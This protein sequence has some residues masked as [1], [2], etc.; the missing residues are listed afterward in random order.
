MTTEETTGGRP[1]A[2]S[3]RELYVN[4]RYEEAFAAA[5]A[6]VKRDSNHTWAYCVCASCLAQMGRAAEGLAVAEQ[7]VALE[8]T[9][10]LALTSRALCLHRLGRDAEA[11]ADYERALALGSD[12]FRVYYNIACYWAERGDERKCRGNFALAVALMRAGD[13]G[14]ISK[15]PDLA[16]YHGRE[17]FKDLLAE[18]KSKKA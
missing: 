7:A 6:L 3:V 10:P 12:D 9:F 15:D 11:E 14:E 16:R 18:A 4:R 5:L 2:V 17:W 13:A 1:R 8:P